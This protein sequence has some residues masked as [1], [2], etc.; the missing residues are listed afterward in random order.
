MRISEHVH[1]SRESSSKNFINSRQ[2]NEEASAE[3]DDAAEIQ[4]SISQ[5]FT[6]K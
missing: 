4:G 5:L 6:T 3:I 1:L 2:I